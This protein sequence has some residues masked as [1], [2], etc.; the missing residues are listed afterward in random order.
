MG[1]LFSKLGIDW[2]LLIANTVTFFIVLWVLRR[3]AYRPIMGV[4]EKR[5]QMAQD[6]VHKSSQVE[7]DL[8]QLQATKDKTIQEARQQARAILQEAKHEAQAAKAELL[9]QAQAESDKIKD[10]TKLVLHREKEEMLRT[11]R[12]ELSDLVVA[13]TGK[14]LQE[15]ITGDIDR[16]LV[17]RSIEAAGEPQP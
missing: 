11:A 15:K 4:L 8:V 2:R 3:Y 5:Q 12:V 1:E 10:Q 17:K 13:A 9:V 6:T 14:V 16:Q 7:Q